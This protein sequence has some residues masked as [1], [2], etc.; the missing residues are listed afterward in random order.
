MI[1]TIVLL[2]FNGQRATTVS[3][4]IGSVGIARTQLC[5]TL[6]PL[7]EGELLESTNDKK[8]LTDTSL[9]DTSR[10]Y[11]VACYACAFVCV[12]VTNIYTNVHA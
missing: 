2:Y 8:L 7:L 6:Q 10:A 4:L 12:Q 1:Q 5:K 9:T 3:D 11:S